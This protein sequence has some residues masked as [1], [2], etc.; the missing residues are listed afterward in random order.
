MPTVG[1]NDP[2]ILPYA[3]RL[4]C[5]DVTSH[6]RC[7]GEDCYTLIALGIGKL[8]GYLHSEG[9]GQRSNRIKP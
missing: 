9:I 4:H 7:Q 2:N 8:D 6:I 3:N 1:L 5:N